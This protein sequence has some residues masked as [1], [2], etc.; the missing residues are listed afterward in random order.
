MDGFPMDI[1]DNNIPEECLDRDVS[2]RLGKQYLSGAIES[3]SQIENEK[4]YRGAIMG[5]SR[6][7]FISIPTSHPKTKKY[8]NMHFLLHTASPIT[9]LTQRALCAIHQL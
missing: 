4:I 9:T 6:R 3:L 7:L 1:L 2:P 8:V 5:R